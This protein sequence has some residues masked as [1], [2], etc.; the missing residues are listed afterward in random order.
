MCNVKSERDLYWHFVAPFL[1]GKDQ[2]FN[3]DNGEIW[4]GIETHIWTEFIQS[5]VTICSAESGE[6]GGERKKW[7]WPN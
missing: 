1:D 7:R 6:G 4:I 5:V 3:E 2:G